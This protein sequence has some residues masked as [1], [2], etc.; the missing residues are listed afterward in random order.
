MNHFCSSL[1][2]NI[3]VLL[4]LLF[5][6]VFTNFTKC[7]SLLFFVDKQCFCFLL[8]FDLRKWGNKISQ[9]VKL[10]FFSCNNTHDYRLYHLSKLSRKLVELLL[11]PKK[12]PPVS[13]EHIKCQTDQPSQLF[14]RYENCSTSLLFLGLQDCVGKPLC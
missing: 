9:R 7:I 10:T 4:L 11:D 3:A 8:T 6:T 5:Y 12:Q 2:E 14:A 1:T 13:S